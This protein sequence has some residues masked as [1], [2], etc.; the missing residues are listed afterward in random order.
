MASG[1]ISIDIVATPAPA[2]VA[3]G[4]FMAADALENML[5]TMY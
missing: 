5:D 2:V 4:F 1:R 3:E